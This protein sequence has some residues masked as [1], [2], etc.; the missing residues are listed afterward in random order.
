MIFFPSLAAL[1]E[2]RGICC[3]I[4]SVTSTEYFADKLAEVVR[5]GLHPSSM[6]RRKAEGDTQANLTGKNKIS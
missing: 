3:Q 4:S 5:S 1:L 6:V 2:R